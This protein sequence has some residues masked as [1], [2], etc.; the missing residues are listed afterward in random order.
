MKVSP[1][2]LG[3]GHDFFDLLSK[4]QATKDKIDEVDFL[5]TINC[6]A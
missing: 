2:D 6:C 1:H 4:A 3:F 5:N